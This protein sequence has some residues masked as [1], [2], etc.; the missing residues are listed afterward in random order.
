MTLKLFIITDTGS[1]ES[2]IFQ[3]KTESFTRT[4]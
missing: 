2:Q 3:L 1:G 4:K